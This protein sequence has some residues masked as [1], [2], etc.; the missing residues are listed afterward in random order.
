[1]AP[2]LSVIVATRNR[3]ALLAR[4]LEALT[5]QRAPRD[6]FEIVVADNGSTD[7]TPDVV[8]AIAERSPC[9]V[10]YVEAAEPGKSHAV[11]AA[12]RHARGELLAFT[13]DD[14]RPDPSWLE[15]IGRA[16]QDPDV[17]FVVGR[18]RP[19]WAVAPP[20]WMSPALFGVLAIP[21]GGPSALPIAAGLNEHIMPIGAN[22]AV[23]AAVVRRLGGLRV[24]LGKLEG[25]LRTGEDH[26]FFL[27]LLQHG[28]RGVYEPRA[29]V[30]HRVPGERLHRGYFR[31]WLY[32]NGRDVALVERMYPR[33][34]RR[35]LGIPRYLWREAASSGIAAAR[36]ALRNDPA[37]RLSAALRVIWIVAYV[38]Q[39]WLGPRLAPL[40]AA[41]ARTDNVGPVASRVARAG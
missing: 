18:I 6:G 8:R 25:T 27:R 14:V 21:D 29:L 23:R 3:H 15:W 11:N 34:A 32:Q 41:A 28:S 13:D 38:R 22:M 10:Q 36:A 7:A 2:Q 17:D 20:S 5:G 9:R 39:T 33:G 31:R 26:E 4:T 16:F 30:H 40:A 35:L 12:L 37:R 24:E 19:D 1:M